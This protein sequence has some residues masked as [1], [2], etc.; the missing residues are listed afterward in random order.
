MSKITLDSVASGYD[1]SKVNANF[2]KIQTEFNNKVLYRDNPVGEVNTLQTSVDVNDQVIYNL[3]EPLLDSQAARLQDVQNAIA[4]GSANLIDFTP[5][6]N[7]TSTNLQAAI[8]E[9]VDDLASSTGASLVGYSQTGVGSVTM[10]IQEDLRETVRASQFGF[11]TTNTAAQNLA[12]MLKAIARVSDGGQIIMAPGLFGS[13]PGWYVDDKNIEIVGSGNSKHYSAAGFAK[14][15]TRVLFN[16]ASATPAISLASLNCS[17]MLRNFAIY[18]NGIGTTGVYVTGTCQM[19]GM[20]VDSFSDTNIHLASGINS[21]IL[22]DI[23]ANSC[24]TGYGIRVGSASLSGNTTFR[25]SNFIAR[26]N[27]IGVR[28]DQAIGYWMDNGVVEGNTAE[29][30]VIFKNTGLQNDHATF[31]NIWLEGN[32]IGNASAYQMVIDGTSAAPS[33]ITWHG[34]LMQSNTSGVRQ[35]HIIRGEDIVF[36]GAPQFGTNG[37]GSDIVLDATAINCSFIRRNGGVIVDNGSFNYTEEQGNCGGPTWSGP[38]GVGGANPSASQGKAGV[39][40]PATENLSS[41]PNTLD[42]YSEYTAA[43]T[44]CTGAITTAVTWKVTKSGNEVKLTLPATVGTGS[45][46]ASFTYGVALPAIY[47][48]TEDTIFPVLVYDN[49]AHAGL[50]AM[51]IT[52]STGV[53]SIYKGSTFTGN[54][55]AGVVDGIVS[56]TSVGWTI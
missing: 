37:T 3:P 12:A 51:S 33:S 6:N 40:F 5:Y 45:A 19:E 55:S 9:E 44:A 28:V 43:S 22:N 24:T 46:A 53:I 21:C 32:N 35:L 29:G 48:P 7:I 23:A 18:G 42:S 4:G 25:I 15:G 20:G 13:D 36:T 52:A 10:S 8:Q 16:T 11:K 47:R 50:G 31:S 30:L 34:G 17:P 56:A 41:D 14:I 54:F 1:L 27:Q 26:G 38:I 39:C 49:G 2:Q